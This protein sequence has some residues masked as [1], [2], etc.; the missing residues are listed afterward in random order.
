MNRE[1]TLIWLYRRDADRA[2]SQSCRETCRICLLMLLYHTTNRPAALLCSLWRR[3]SQDSAHP[4][5]WLR[6][7]T[8]LLH[9]LEARRSL[10]SEIH[11]FLGF[12]SN[13]SMPTNRRQIS[14]CFAF[15]FII[16]SIKRSSTH[17]KSFRFPTKTPFAPHS[18]QPFL[19]TIRKQIISIWW[20][21]IIVK[22]ST[23]ALNGFLVA[24]DELPRWCFHFL[25]T[26]DLRTVEMW[27]RK[28][29]LRI[30]AAFIFGVRRQ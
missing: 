21:P 28:R 23:S 22:W 25:S 4:A 10:I 2:A 16:I 26:S 29:N 8:R 18:P 17:P 14:F 11:K 24:F 6:N 12:S 13:D 5:R 3:L 7:R 1:L 20:L 15:S 9:W 27:R 19:R 30:C